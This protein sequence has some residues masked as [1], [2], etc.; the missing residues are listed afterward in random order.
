MPWNDTADENTTFKLRS[1][2]K[3]AVYFFALCTSCYFQK[4]DWDV[5]SF[6]D[7]A[8]LPFHDSW[9]LNSILL[10]IDITLPLFGCF[11]WN[12]N[13]CKDLSGFVTRIVVGWK[14]DEIGSCHSIDTISVWRG[15]SFSFSGCIEREGKT[16]YNLIHSK[17]S[18]FK[19]PVTT[20]SKHL[21]PK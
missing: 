1:I 7:F 16:S 8:I 9:T 3:D 19:S 17:S 20:H 12:K 4:Y 6:K 5:R 18:T 15:K 2:S 21:F 10:C 11:P 14:L 13:N